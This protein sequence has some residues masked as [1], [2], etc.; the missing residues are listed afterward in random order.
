VIIEKGL[1]NN[2]PG[3]G[4]WGKSSDVQPKNCAT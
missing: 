1:E 4:S 3:L 2:S